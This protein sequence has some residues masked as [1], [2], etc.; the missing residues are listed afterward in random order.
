MHVHRLHLCHDHIIRLVNICYVCVQE[1]SIIIDKIIAMAFY[2]TAKWK[3]KL[4]KILNNITSRCI[5]PVLSV[6]NSLSLFQWKIENAIK[7]RTHVQMK[8]H[9]PFFSGT[10]FVCIGLK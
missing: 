1:W 9:M 6:L 4:K 3:K 5:C 2:V 7:K 8:I 10:M